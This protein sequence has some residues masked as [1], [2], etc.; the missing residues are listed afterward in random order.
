MPAIRSF[1]FAIGFLLP[2]M[3]SQAVTINRMEKAEQFMGEIEEKRALEGYLD[4]LK[5][6]PEH[7]EA[8]WNASQ[9]Y[10]VI[11]NRQEDETDQKKFYNKA[12]GLARKA[13]DRYPDKG[14]PY[15]VMAMT[16]GRMSKLAGIRERIQLAHA[17]EEYIQHAVRLMP[18]HAASWH[19]YGIWQSEVANVSRAERIGARL[20]SRGLPDG[21]NEKA[22]EFLEKA[23]EL[24]SD[25]ILIRLDLARHFIRSNQEDRAIPVLEQLL[26]RDLPITWKDDPNHLE[27]AQALLQD[28]Q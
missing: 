26:E 24:N 21:T 1:L 13:L 10:T 19:L 4:V 2:A 3:T 8:L 17:M 11:G 5:E 20:I 6:D 22:E 28:L 15:F 12:K 7:Y 23:M 9:L 25:S 14:H 18:D 27:T 16:K